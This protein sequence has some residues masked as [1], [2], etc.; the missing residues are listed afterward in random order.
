MG[1]IAIAANP[2]SGKDI[3]RLVS[4]A[5]VVDNQEKKNIVERIILAIAQTGEHEICLMPDSFGFFSKITKRLVHDLGTLTP[6]IITKCD[7]LH[8][9]SDKDTTEFARLMEKR[10]ADVLIVLGGD[11][12]SRAASKQIR[13]LPLIPVSTGTN[14]VFPTMVEGTVVGMAASALATGYVA[15]S[16][17][18][19]RCKRIEVFK[20]GI[21]ADIAL[22]DAVFSPQAIIG[23]KALW[24]RDDI[25]RVI[26][27]Q[28]HP[29]TIGFSAIAGSHTIVMPE[30]DGGVAVELGNG[31]ANTKVP[32]AAGVIEDI[33]INTV[34]RLPLGQEYTYIATSR[35]CVALDG[36]REV[37]YTKGD[38]ISLVIN[39]NGPLRV[40]LIKA[41]TISQKGGFYKSYNP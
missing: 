9:E 17:C 32:L 12:T 26:V 1:L 34:T 23:S 5:F 6:G 27:T 38:K 40:D 11:G 37:V 8:T 36:E 7:M 10:G 14:N 18:C 2:A 35:G 3:R 39:R 19:T 21:F 28:C 31:Q 4:H 25:D 33:C 15:P 20:N 41:L 29:A 24:E 30:D 16:Q 22:I 13:N